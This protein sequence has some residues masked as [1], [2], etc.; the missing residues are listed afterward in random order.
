MLLANILSSRI[1]NDIALGTTGGVIIGLVGLSLVMIWQ[2]THVL[3]FAQGSMAM[4]AT[5]LGLINIEHGMNVWLAIGLSVLAGVVV[6]AVTERTIVRPLYGKPELNSIVV[7]IGLSLFLTTLA[8]S[9]WSNYPHI[10]TSPFSTTYFMSGDTA[11][12]LSPFT[13]FQIVTSVVVMLA[14]AALF[15]FTKLGLQ[16]RASAISPEVAKLLGVRVGRMLTIGWAL[17]TAVG[18]VA[19]VVMG[20]SDFGL[21]PIVLD[22][23]FVYGFI[24]AAVGGLES[25]TGALI[26]GVLIGIITQFVT[27]YKG[28]SYA[29]FVCVIILVIS[30]LAR[31]QGILSLIHI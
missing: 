2:S 18:A 25:P 3:N 30:L 21:T 10:F 23:I 6:G 24:A 5:F 12:G 9:I 13:L 29:M 20:L 31:P 17:S 26:S 11:T 15:K 22:S 28:V 4:F 1:A 16:L 14:V 7:M 8:T 19:G 27:D